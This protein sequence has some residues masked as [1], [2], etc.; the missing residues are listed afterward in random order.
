MEEWRESTE[1]AG[2]EPWEEGGCTQAGCVGSFM[3]GSEESVDRKQDQT[4]TNVVWTL[5]TRSP[6]CCQRPDLVE[7][8]NHAVLRR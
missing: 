2:T 7:G 4:H 1:K 8:E 3:R 5:E 6:W